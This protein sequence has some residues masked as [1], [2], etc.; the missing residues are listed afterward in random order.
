MTFQ[1]GSL[2]ALP[3]L[4]TNSGPR[5]YKET[6]GLWRGTDMKRKYQ[7][8]KRSIR[9]NNVSSDSISCEPQLERS[10]GRQRHKNKLC[11]ENKSDCKDAES[12]CMEDGSAECGRM[13]FKDPYS[14][15]SIEICIRLGLHRRFICGRVLSHL[16]VCLHY[17]HSKCAPARFFGRFMCGTFAPRC[18]KGGAL[19]KKSRNIATYVCWL[20]LILQHSLI[21]LYSAATSDT[22]HGC[23]W[24]FFFCGE[25]DK[26][27]FII[28]TLKVFRGTSDKVPDSKI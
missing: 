6:D 27:F 20:W 2:L 19:K 21:H 5:S 24:R 9:I 15:L 23:E 8:D 13:H 14:N 3:L 22:T 18:L 25:K 17:S 26:Y 10:P 7:Q 16:S 11:V 1:V 4:T 12:T 28:S